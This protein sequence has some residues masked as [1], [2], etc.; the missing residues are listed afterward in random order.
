[1]SRAGGVSLSVYL[2]PEPAARSA[3]HFPKSQIAAGA[4][5]TVR[6]TRQ[7]AQP[8]RRRAFRERR[9]E[10]QEWGFG[11]WARSEPGA[12]KSLGAPEPPGCPEPH[13][14]GPGDAGNATACSPRSRCPRDPGAPC[15]PWSAAP[16]E[17]GAPNARPAWPW[18]RH[19]SPL[20]DRRAT[21][22]QPPV[23]PRKP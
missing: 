2:R 7:P 14:L 9:S 20:G 16:G 19:A 4:S 10:D 8:R 5:A 6:S 18:Q 11:R 13:R 1:M 17:D 15:A 12:R 21:A 22:A 3:R 23:P